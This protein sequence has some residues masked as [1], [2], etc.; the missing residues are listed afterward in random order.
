[1][2]PGA[3]WEVLTRHSNRQPHEYDTE[4]L[5][6]QRLA[7]CGDAIYIT[8]RIIVKSSVRRLL[9]TASVV[10][11]LLILVTLMK[12]ALNSSAT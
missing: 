1:L 9:L 6:L 3:L 5:H 4:I 11:S 2:T 12:E 8:V 10:P 7:L